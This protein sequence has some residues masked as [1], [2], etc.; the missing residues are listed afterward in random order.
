MEDLDV[1]QAKEGPTRPLGVEHNAV[2]HRTTWKDRR[3]QKADKIQPEV[4]VIG[5]G[6]G[7]L[8]AAAQLGRLGVETLI[9][10]KNERIGGESRELGGKSTYD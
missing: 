2:T 10:E 1:A 5:G 8:T 6:Q 9:V 4:V 3:N 7:G